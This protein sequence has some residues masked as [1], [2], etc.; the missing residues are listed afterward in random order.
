MSKSPLLIQKSPQVSRQLYRQ[1]HRHKRQPRTPKDFK[2]NS[3]I[4]KSLPHSMRGGTRR[5]KRTQK[6]R[7]TRR[8][9][10]VPKQVDSSLLHFPVLQ[11]QR[12]PP[13]LPME[14]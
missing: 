13:E 11:R 10:K 4:K 9:S 1:R 2:R 7:S 12:H 3:T 5:R 8:N 6:S 14:S